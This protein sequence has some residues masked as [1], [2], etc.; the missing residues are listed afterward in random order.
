MK[1]IQAYEQV[2]TFLLGRDRSPLDKQ[3]FHQLSLV[4]F[5]AWVGLGADGLSSV[6]YGPEEAFRA[7]HGHG[8]LGIVVGLMTALTVAIIGISYSQIVELFP[9]GGGG[10]LVASKLLSPMAGVV[11]G[12]ALLIDYVLTIS[13]SIAAG[14]AAIFSFFSPEWG[15]YKLAVAMLSVV[16]IAVL[17]LRGIRESVAPLVPIFLVFLVTHVFAIA[18]AIASNWTH[19]GTL[20]AT[21][22]A[23]FGQLRGEIGLTGVL[24]LLIRSFSMGAGTFT[25]LEAV[26]NGLPILREPRVQTAHKTMRYMIISLAFLAMG[27]LTAYFLC[28]VHWAAGKTMNAV[29]MEN[30]TAHWNTGAARTFVFITLLSEA[31]LL[32]VAAQ[33]GFLDG[34]RVLASM[35]LDRWVPS[36]FATL[37]DHLV[38]RNGVLLMTAAS[39][40]VLWLTQG[41]IQL[42]VV[43]Y[44]INVFITFTLSQMGMVRH[45]W[46]V[47]GEQPRWRRKLCINGLGLLVTAGILSSVVIAK[48][49]EGGWITLAV[50]GVL[51]GLAYLI[52]G[53]YRATYR[54]LER[55][56][57]LVEVADASLAEAQPAPAATAV[58]DPK[59]K[60]AVVLVNGFNGLGLHTMFAILRLFSHTFRNFIFVQVGIIDVGNFKGTQELERL[61][62]S[63][64][65]DLERYVRYA[66][67]QGLCSES[68]GSVSQ[69]VAEE[70]ETLAPR[71]AR[72][73]PNAVF[74]GGQLVFPEENL[75]ARWFYNFIIFSIQRR[76]HLMGIPFIV[77]PIRIK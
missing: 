20:I 45:W 64:R 41:S 36:F 51:I 19:A 66:R 46:Q 63:V 65:D 61:Q 29:L 62:N 38:T 40:L 68:V 17:N 73:F 9:S 49:H 3:V 18:Y 53:Y 76:L 11:S 22:T 12:C 6:C 4:A 2:K 8:Y 24:F 37:S 28:D 1:L 16:F 71:I 74:F 75:F 58:C 50:T 70:I 69:D 30:L 27:L 59:V 26:S 60:T 43:L 57:D 48:F 35:A 55:L 67:S 47:R 44:S 21:S 13:M 5:L 14:S 54:H 33:T 72:R 10:Y 25:G 23:Q 32:L 52:R 56:N 34:P 39:L 77:L 7:L 31:I 15:Q 42:L